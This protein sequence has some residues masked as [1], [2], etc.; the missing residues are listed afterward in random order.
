M[1]PLPRY[2]NK[3]YVVKLNNGSTYLYEGNYLDLIKFEVEK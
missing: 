3:E 2:K 1:K